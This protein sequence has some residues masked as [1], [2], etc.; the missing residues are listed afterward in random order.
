MCSVV[1]E[2][3]KTY[4]GFMLCCAVVWKF[5]AAYLCSSCC[6]VLLCGSSVQHTCAML[7]VSFV[8]H[9]CAVVSV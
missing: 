9:S 4:K 3:V 1:E 6:V 2:Q 5:S 8:R 7:S